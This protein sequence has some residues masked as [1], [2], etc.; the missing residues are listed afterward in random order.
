MLLSMINL[1]PSSKAASKFTGDWFID[2]IPEFLLLPFV[3]YFSMAT[4]NANSVLTQSNEYSS[5]I[6]AH[7]KFSLAKFMQN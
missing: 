7:E 2:C 6:V 3:C 4:T 1:Y 5:T